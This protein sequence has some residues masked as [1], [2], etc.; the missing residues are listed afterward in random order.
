MNNT[1]NGLEPNSM[2]LKVIRNSGFNDVAM[3]S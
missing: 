3:T 1:D 2:N